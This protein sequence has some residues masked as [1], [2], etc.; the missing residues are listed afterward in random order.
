MRSLD[1]KKIIIS[2]LDFYS[3]LYTR[4]ILA[5]PV[6]DNIVL[7]GAYTHIPCNPTNDAGGFTPF[8]RRSLFA[9]ITVRTITN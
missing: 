9:S 3:T 2:V 8:G 7:G 1:L 6:S 4:P 5:G